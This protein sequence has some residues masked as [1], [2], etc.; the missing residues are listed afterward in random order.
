MGW[1][2]GKQRQTKRQEMAYQEESTYLQAQTNCYIRELS[3]IAG[4]QS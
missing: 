2:T 4:L 1:I 3:C